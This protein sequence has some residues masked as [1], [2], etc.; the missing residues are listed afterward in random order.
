M[1][2]IEIDTDIGID[3]RVS[4]SIGTEWT[5]AASRRNLR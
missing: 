3:I 5:A 1:I 2:T 4:I